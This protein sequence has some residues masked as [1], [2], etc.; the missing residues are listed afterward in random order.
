MTIKLQTNELV[1]ILK[2]AALF[3]HNDRIIPVINAVHLE[4]RGRELVA[5]AT[6]R[7]A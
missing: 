3:A 5:V 4:A 7:F 2:E 6:D 1:R